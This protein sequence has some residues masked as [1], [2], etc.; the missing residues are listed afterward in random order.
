MSLHLLSQAQIAAKQTEHCA[1]EV[2][3]SML[4]VIALASDIARWPSHSAANIES[5]NAI[6]KQLDRA[7]A[8][9]RALGGQL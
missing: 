4:D 5:L 3:D 8:S 6:R 7:E 9:S 2:S 1:H